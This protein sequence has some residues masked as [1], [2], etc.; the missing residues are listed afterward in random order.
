MPHWVKTILKVL[1]GIIAIVIVAFI[2]VT[3]YVV[4]NKHKVLNLITTELNKNLNGTLTIGGLNPTF[5]KGFPGVSVALK[6]VT[7]KDKLWANHHHTLLSAKDIYVSVDASALLK[8][9]VN[10]NKVEISNANIDLFTDSTGYSNTAVFKSKQQENKP[11][12]EKGSSSTQIKRFELNNVTFIVDDRK[13]Y[14]LFKFEVQD[15]DGK[16]DYPATGWKANL[17]LKTLVKSFSFNTKK[18]SFIKDK[19]LNGPFDISYDNKNKLI[20][21]APRS[22]ACT[23]ASAS[24]LVLP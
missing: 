15:I 7:L 14:K 1:G 18:G 12:K 24:V 8:G 2:G 10:I 9:T 22:T 21:V 20:T 11:T 3:I 17:Q 5:F 19:L 4:Y 13:A 16:M 23:M 6:D